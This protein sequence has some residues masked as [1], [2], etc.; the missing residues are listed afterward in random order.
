VYFSFVARLFPLATRRCKTRSIIGLVLFSLAE[1]NDV[2]L[3]A[4]NS[5]MALSFGGV[6]DPDFYGTAWN[7]SCWAQ[8]TPSSSE[9]FDGLQAHGQSW[10]AAPLTNQISCQNMQISRP[11]PGPEQNPPRELFEFKL[12]PSS[13]SWV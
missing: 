12:T 5:A 11:L 3:T 6:A 10:A 4:L 13:A 1:L 7:L 8:R 2:V 9:G